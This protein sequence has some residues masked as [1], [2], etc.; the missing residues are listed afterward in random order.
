MSARYLFVKRTSS[1]RLRLL[2]WGIPLLMLALYVSIQSQPSKDMGGNLPR[3]SNGPAVSMAD[4]SPSAQT[5]SGAAIAAQALDSS[6]ESV[7][8]QQPSPTAAATD[9]E[10]SLREAL[11]QW[12]QAWSAKNVAQYLGFYGPDFVPS[13]YPDRTVWEQARKQRISSKKKIHLAIHNLHVQINN[14]TSMV[15]FTQVYA[16]E[17]LHTTDHKTM[18]WQKIDARW[19]IQ[20]E[21]TD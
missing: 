17:R 19:L 12:Q 4:P 3:P 7:Q 6:S 11:K 21:V 8:A 18:V 9:E 10:A 2:T 15:N 16:D 13:Q 14:N 5:H 20:R 1:L